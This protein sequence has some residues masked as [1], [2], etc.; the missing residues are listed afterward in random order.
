[1]TEATIP[2]QRR[3]DLVTQQANEPGVWVVKD[4]LCLKYFRLAAE[5]YFVLD[6]LRNQQSM[7]SLTQLMR[8]A[9][10]GYIYSEDNLRTFVASLAHSNLLCPKHHKSGV[11]PKAGLLNRIAQS[12]LLSVKLGSID[13]TRFFDTLAP[14]RW[15]LRFAFWSG[16]FLIA[17]A[18]VFVVANYDAI[19]SE[20]P[21]MRQLVHPSNLILLSV[22]FVAIKV[23]HELGHVAACRY[24]GKECHEMGLL[25]LVFTPVMYCDVSDAWMIQK[26][27]GRML[28][29]LAG[30]V[31]EMTLAA[32]S[33]FLWLNTA[34]GPE[35]F[36]F[37]NIVIICSINTIFV[38]GNPLLRYDG[39]YALA[40]LV[41]IPNLSSRARDTLW[42]YFDRIVL[43]KGDGQHAMSAD[44]R[45][46][47][48]I[49]LW[50]GVISGV[51]RWFVL[52]AILWFVY[53]L[54][55]S[56]G[57]GPLAIIV[58]LPAL[59]A[60]FLPLATNLIQRSRRAIHNAT[61]HARLRA[62]VG[63]C[64]LV[65]AFGFLL[66]YPLP[67]YVRAPFVIYPPSEAAVHVQQNGTLENLTAEQS[68][69]QR[70]TQL[71][72]LT[73]PTL[74]LEL[75]DA[76][77]EVEL[78]SRRFKH[79]EAAQGRD[80][81]ARLSIPT[82]REQKQSALRRM[83]G[84]NKKIEQLTIRSPR[85]GFVYSPPNTPMQ[86]EDDDVLAVRTWSGSP[87]DPEN[88]DAYLPEQS[89]LCF[90]ATPEEFNAVM[91]VSQDQLELVKTSA[92]IEYQFRSDPADTVRGAVVDFG[93]FRSQEV[94]REI[95]AAGLA[96]G[97]ESAT[98][99]QVLGSLPAAFESSL[100]ATGVARIRCQD[101]SIMERLKRGIRRIFATET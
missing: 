32:I 8:K 91:F 89:L 90:V 30:V 69:V 47:E 56:I 22:A 15:A 23:L 62:I 31:V 70:G 92:R 9:F 35:H 94:S 25:L 19:I 68:S 96:N 73:N 18:F 74:A 57:I 48:Q 34:P 5:E 24:F 49:E 88:A 98:T 13:P 78:L 37:L 11:S 81:A 87:F 58:A 44:Q 99:Y 50:Y 51:Y 36:F 3:L 100:Y 21:A 12:S 26:K 65:A 6:C 86:V 16:C 59:L 52:F 38:N 61:S 53:M 60:T 101:A 28:V 43:G 20:L 79:L 63:L 39:Y 54:F 10:P 97:A 55:R 64:V 84:I 33:V 14:F 85:Q 40:D 67:Q 29:S 27:S 46:T 93:M 42:R 66:W 1:M 75:Q 2:Y 17:F 82:V 71:A 45:R 83:A 7:A 4:P 72:T 77:G 95:M 76:K 80:E 41:E